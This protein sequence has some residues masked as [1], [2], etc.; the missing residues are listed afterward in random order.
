[1][2]FLT[3]DSIVKERAI[4]YI[5]ESSGTPKVELQT[6]YG[7]SF[8]NVVKFSSHASKNMNLNPTDF[9]KTKLLYVPS[10]KGLIFF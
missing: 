1:V 7:D 4:G 6:L 9:G 2:Y 5:P 3:N 8:S 10:T